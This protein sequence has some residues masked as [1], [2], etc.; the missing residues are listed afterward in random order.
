MKKDLFREDALKASR[1]KWLGEILLVS[2]LNVRLITISATIFFVLCLFL[3]CYGKYTRR[4]IVNGAVIPEGGVIKIYSPQTGLVSQLIVSEGQRVVKGQPLYVISS[5]RRGGENST[6]QSQISKQA[7]LRQESFSDEIAKTRTM[8]KEERQSLSQKIT[9]LESGV[10]NLASQIELQH[11]QVAIAQSLWTRYKGL[12]EQNYISGPQV[13]EKQAAL[14]AQKSR[15]QSSEHELI[16]AA[17]ELEERRSEERT[18]ETKQQS[19][20][21]LLSRSLAA[22]KQEFIES[23]AKREVI[24][25]APEAGVVTGIFSD[26]GQAVEITRPLLSITR[27]SNL[28]VRLYV[29][30]RLVGSV[31]QGTTVRV[32]Y[33]AFPYQRYGVGLAAVT[34]VSQVAF[35]SSE[36]SGAGN[37]FTRQETEPMYVVDAKLISNSTSRPFPEKLRPGMQ[38]EAEIEQETRRLIEWIFAPL[39]NLYK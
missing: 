31:L 1:G 29:P 16:V 19:S 23:E 36:L 37:L 28:Q 26:K 5:D 13:E 7:Q 38:V 9:A 30:S 34:S 20:L 6:I 22:T 14:L 11:A 21:A 35:S 15:L 10:K 24:I 2:P 27:N 3:L 39:Y 25:V 33:Q 12:Q 4:G 32:R 8:Q 18:L 17:L